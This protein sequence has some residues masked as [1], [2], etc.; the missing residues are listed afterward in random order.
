MLGHLY[1]VRMLG[2]LL[3]FEKEEWKHAV[4]YSVVFPPDPCVGVLT[5]EKVTMSGDRVFKELLLSR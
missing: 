4:L 3:P 2:F 5:H 1:G